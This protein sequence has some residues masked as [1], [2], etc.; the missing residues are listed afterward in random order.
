MKFTEINFR[1]LCSV[2]AVICY[3]QPAIYAQNTAY[4]TLFTN[5]TF[6]K[7][8]NVVL[9]VG[10]TPGAAD[11][12]NGSATYTIPIVVPPG[13]NGITPQVSVTYNSMGGSSI[14]GFGWDISSISTITR[15]GQTIYND[16]I[17]NA[18]PVTLGSTDK[19]ALDGSRLLSK[20]GTYGANGTTYGTEIENFS[21][22]TSNGSF[23]GDPDWFK[24]EA[25]DGT[26]MYYGNST[27]SKFTNENNT[28]IL[29][30]RLNKIEYKDG[31]YIEFKYTSIDRDHRISEINYTKNDAA[32]LLAYNKI[33]F[34]YLIRTDVNTSFIAGSAVK[35]K[36]LLDKITV[37]AEA[38][39][40][41][42][43]YTFKYATNNN[44]NSFLKEV[45]ET[46][47]NNTELNSTIFKYG[48][49]PTELQT[50]S[51]NAIIGSSDII[52]GDLNGDGYSDLVGFTRNVN[53]SIV[54]HTEFK[55]YTKSPSASNDT[56][57][58]GTTVSLPANYIAFQP[59]YGSNTRR[60]AADYNGDGA[61]DIILTQ[62]TG[63]GASRTMNEVRIYESPVS[64]ATYAPPIVLTPYNGWN[65]VNPT[66]NYVQIGDFNGDGRSDILTMLGQTSSLFKMAMR[67]GG[68]SYWSDMGVSG[69]VFF[70]ESSWPSADEI[71]ILDFDGD[72]K[73]DIMIIKDLSC[74]IF[75]FNSQQTAVSIY[76]SGFPTKYH[77]LFLGD[78]NGDGKTDILSRTSKTDNNASWNKAL[79]TGKGFVETPFTFNTKPDINQAYYGHKILIADY[80]GDGK[81]DILHGWSPTSASSNI[82]TY[83]ST[84]EG[85]FRKASTFAGYFV[86]SPTV[87]NFDHNGDGRSDIM[88]RHFINDPF[89][90]L[91]FNK[92]GKD[93]LLHKI[94]NGVN[95]TTELTYKRM[96]EGGSFYTR[97][98]LTAHPVNNIQIPLNL[99]Y[100]LTAENGIGGNSIVR[101]SYESAKLH[102]EGHGLMGY[103]KIT[104]NNLATGMT[105]VTENEFNSTFH[106]SAPK[107]SSKYLNSLYTLLS[108]STRTNVFSEQGTVGSK[109]IWIK[110]TDSQ[111]SDLFQKR[112]IYETNTYD[113]YG[114]VTQNT[115]NINGEET[116]TTTAQYGTFGTPIPCK[117]TS[118]TISNTRYGS[119]AAST[120]TTYT[121]NTLG[122]MTG[123]VDFSG[124]PKS[125]TTTYTYNNLGNQTGMTLTPSGMTA[126]ST[127]Y[128]YDSKGRYVLTTTN[129]LGQTATAVY[130]PKWG[131]PTSSTGID[132]LTTTY[133]YDAFGRVSINT[134]PTGFT[135]T[136]AYS[137]DINATAGTVYTKLSTHP[138]KPD[139]KVWFDVLDRTKQTQT[140]GFLGQWIT[141]KTTYDSRGNIATV[142]DPYK[143]GETVLTTTNTYDA[144][145]RIT[146]QA[147]TLGT[148]TTAYSY[149]IDGTLTTTIT[150]PGGRSHIKVQEATGK[151]IIATDN[152]GSLSYTYDNQGNLTQTNRGS[153]ALV[154][155]QYD[156]Y[157]KQTKMIDINAGTTDFGYDALGQMTSQISPLSQT[158][159]MTYDLL[160]RITQKVGP[161]GTTTTEYLPSGSG[162]S[163]NQIKKITG[164]SGDLEEFTYDAFGRISTNKVT[165]DGIPHTSS[166]SYN[167]YSDITSKTYPS[168]FVVNYAYD[169]NG[170]LNTLKNGTNTVTMFTNTGM[171]GFNQYTGYTLGN[172]KASTNTYYFGI[173]TRYLTTGIQDLNLSWNYQTGNLNSRNDAIKGKTETFTY[174]NLNRLLT[175]TVTGLTAITMTYGTNGNIN[176]KTDAGNYTYGISKINAVTQVTNPNINIPLSTQNVSYTSF[177]Q[178]A[179]I[180]E[181]SNL[182]TYTY[183]ADQQRI[184]SVLTQN[185]S[186]TNQKY[187]FS[188]YEKDIT[189]SSVKHLHYIDAGN[190]VIAIVV[191]ETGT[192]TYNYTYI[193]H[194]GSI[195]T[196][197][198][199]IGTVTAEQNFDAWGRKRNTTTWTYTG[200][201]TVPAWLYRGFTG[202]EHLSPFNLINMNGRLYDPLVGRMLSTDSKI[203]APDFTQNYNR[204]SYALNNPL[205]FTDPDGEEIVTAIVIGAIIGAYI[206]GTLANGTYNPV[207]WDYSSGKTWGYMLA[208]AVVGGVSAGLGASVAASGAPFANTAGIAFSSIFNSIGTS[209]YTGGQT[210]VSVSLGIASYNFTK[211]EWGYLGK[212][213]NSVVE[214]I[215]YGFG[216]LANLQDAVA[217]TQGTNI[218]VLARKEFAGHSEIRGSD[219]STT[220]S[221]GPTNFKNKYEGRNV[222]AL[223]WE[224]QFI[225]PVDARNVRFIEP[226]APRFKVQLNN[227]NGKL[228][229]NMTA[230]LNDG[231]NLL[232]FGSFKYGLGRG[233]INYTSRALLYAGVPTFSALMPLWSP[234]CLTFELA[235]RQMGIYA[236]PILTNR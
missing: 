216:A 181:G 90:I 87:F 23:G 63:T 212:K 191:R 197:T 189:G 28:E 113:Q 86:T 209:L 148:A 17:V 144:Y 48:D 149:G 153:T 138:G 46:G 13:T 182:L 114:N 171:N 232:G 158:T 78:L 61:A 179:T 199:N 29:L 130:D 126:R 96:T 163:T 132:G 57:V 83:Y 95:H 80:N 224:S 203:Q 146:S 18:I 230:N 51:S 32:G 68:Q 225:K 137:W 129:V 109:R 190:G 160:G 111:I 84:G 133:Q 7:T 69:N 142:T 127:S 116:R 152:G 105:S 31:N 175:S 60:A 220:I 85:F 25:K 164:F 10:A 62:T 65:I 5:S 94:K 76:A 22:I 217:L 169:A 79:S 101:Y 71:H 50:G 176:S 98:S 222:S 180:T 36:Y 93:L 205:R 91:Q 49:L 156:V 3:Q 73:D 145:N 19:F 66:G 92:E 136:E 215:G 167:I 134:L 53:G 154:I 55:T 24:V 120:T 35:R 70:D 210:D 226:G 15:I 184:K 52:S 42:K 104:T 40:A 174:D 67:Y 213:G 110:N 82:D 193:D 165:V 44:I 64:G 155:N 150:D 30:W 112:N 77:L 27:D 218:D 54:Y 45:I 198:N 1:L 34:S 219:E 194:I 147:N 117:P 201:Q 99:A 123:K 161:E 100:E 139:L 178:P 135:V 229:K 37:T 58:L 8:V 125:V 2:F 88:S 9:P 97:G 168:G 207:A 26:V 211:N 39:A 4:T 56:Y 233:C 166:Y 235:V 131:K 41:F 103:Y 118:S 20:T 204:Y 228:M 206:G 214:N 192:D 200:V 143:T 223:K 236:A 124:L 162:A 75:T 89:N 38:N 141:T 72:G 151:V 221:V 173:P 195:L 185:G 170:Y 159:T 196:V 186:V 16:A 43:I 231:K 6:T 59:T 172:G 187:Y 119:P 33:A 208:G 11:A 107:K 102:K 47:S 81:S 106:F 188:D 115:L 140:E 177:F 234:V 227:V 21:T 108:E 128:A 12:G 183:G 202:H 74:E 121:Y 122:Q 14:A 157:G